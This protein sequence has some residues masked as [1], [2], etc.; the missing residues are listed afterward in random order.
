MLFMSTIQAQQVQRSTAGNLKNIFHSQVYM[1]F[2]ELLPVYTLWIA[3]T[4]LCP[5]IFTYSV[6]I[7]SYFLG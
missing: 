4:Q 7:M 5:M 1:K 2:I 3:V 6:I